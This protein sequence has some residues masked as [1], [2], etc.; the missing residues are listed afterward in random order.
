M[1]VHTRYRNLPALHKLQPEP[2]VR[3][4]PEDAIERGIEEGEQTI[5]E[6][7]EGSIRIKAKVTTETKRGVVVIDFGWGNPWDGGANVNVLT[8]DSIRDPIS[9]TTPNRCFACQAKKA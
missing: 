7:P 1:Y 6:S 5:V 3:L 2:L 8:T 9:S 4:H